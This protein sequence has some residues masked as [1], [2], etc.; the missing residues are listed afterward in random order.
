MNQK[1]RKFSLFALSALGILIV[2]AAVMLHALFI[3]LHRSLAQ[4]TGK[5]SLAGLE[6]PV[7]VVRDRWGV[8]HIFAQSQHDALFAEGF[9]HAQDRLWQM[10]FS[11]RMGRGR[12]AEI[13]GQPVVTLDRVARVANFAALAQQTVSALPTSAQQA[14]LAYSAGVNAFLRGHHG[15]LPPELALLGINP[16]P[17]TP[18]DSVILIKLMAL[19]LSANAWSELF[20]TKFLQSHTERE[21]A[22]LRPELPPLPSLESLYGIKLPKKSALG[23]TRP[24]QGA[25]NN[26]VVNGQWTKS[27]KPLLANDPHLGL[28]IPSVFYLAH[29]AIGGRNII[30]A[31]LSG[32]PGIILGRNDTLAWAFTNTG[33]D[34]QDFTLE[35]LSVETPGHYVTASGKRPFS[36]REE[37]I[38][39]RGGKPLHETYRVSQHGPIVPAD[40]PLIRDIIPKGYALALN[41]DALKANDLTIAAGLGMMQAPDGASF[42]RALEP[43]VA[44]MQNMVYADAFGHIGLIAPGHV[45]VRAPGDDTH[46]LLPVPGWKPGYEWT[47]IIP[48]ADLPQR[49]D[50]AEG[51]IVTANNKIVDD[52]YAHFLS[53]EWDPGARAKRITDLLTARRDHD[54]ASF[55]AIQRDAVSLN[56]SRLLPMLLARLAPFPKLDLD[57][58]ILGL[59]SRWDGSMAA[60]RPEPLIFAAWMREINLALNKNI[61]EDAADPMGGWAFPI[62]ARIGSDDSGAMQF[63]GGDRTRE[64]CDRVLHRSFEEMVRNLRMLQGEWP[65]KWRWGV[66]HRAQMQNQPLGTLPILGSLINRAIASDGGADTIN[67]GITRIDSSDPFSNIHG[68]TYRAVYDLADPDKSLFMIS[69]GQ[70]GNPLSPHYDDLVRPW[71]KGEYIPMI[72]TRARLDPQ[73][74]STLTLLPLKGP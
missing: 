8:P 68:S 57:R 72:T 35:K 18:E 54:A 71:A 36:M 1:L 25:S 56:A 50:P 26:W 47:G 19:Q 33:S 37:E 32:V 66:A 67:R 5:I 30:G 6:A 31:S 34:V 53:Y 44:P 41:W 74:S 46:G 10:E 23:M 70:S 13:L 45:P 63:C 43:Y 4:Q 16:E 20:N 73:T 21:L 15:P 49:A 9:V 29:L 60:D 58:E 17:W 12:L 42:V 24:L 39:V 62:I 38:R 3:T 40:L 27:G 51:Y 14:L 69:T 59:L 28:S 55:A 48:F 7:D 22:A 64:A 61:G 65:S 11:R 52:R 2:L